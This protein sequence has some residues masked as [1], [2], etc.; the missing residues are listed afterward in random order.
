MKTIIASAFIVALAIPALAQSSTGPTPAPASPAMAA[1]TAPTE[2]Q[3]KQMVAHDAR[4]KAI[5]YEACDWP[6]KITTCQDVQY[7]DR[8]G[9]LRHIENCGQTDA[10]K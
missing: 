4:G 6:G 1:P 9:S 5:T 10:P 2:L 7:V 8:K 3:C